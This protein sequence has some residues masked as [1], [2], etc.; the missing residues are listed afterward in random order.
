MKY[1]K[2]ILAFIFVLILA[3]AC[4]NPT[5]VEDNIK[6]TALEKSISESSGLLIELDTTTTE[7]P[8]ENHIITY[9]TTNFKGN[10]TGL[11][12]L[13]PFIDVFYL[14]ERR[15][16]WFDAFKIEL[17]TLNKLMSISIDIKTNDKQ[18][19]ERTVPAER[20]SKF[21]IQLKDIDF[22]NPIK[23]MRMNS[24]LGDSHWSS[25]TVKAMPDKNDSSYV[26]IEPKTYE[27]KNSYA[28]FNL[29]PLYDEDTGEIAAIGLSFDFEA[30]M[31]ASYPYSKF[32]LTYQM[33]LIF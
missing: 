19:Y 31:I 26:P 11:M 2:N 23:N 13:Y 5:E 9:D 32:V 6:K 24:P 22:T 12:E 21:Q 10:H 16:F 27:G 4:D 3:V 28:L 33:T 15:V 8:V 18:R 25:Y 30:E 20:I 17:D 1:Y 14:W 7:P 29:Q